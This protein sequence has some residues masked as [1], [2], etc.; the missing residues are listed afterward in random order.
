MNNSSKRI[1]IT[2]IAG[3][4]QAKKSAETL[5]FAEVG[6]MLGVSAAFISA[7]NAITPVLGGA[8]FDALGSTAPFLAGG[9]LLFLLLGVAL[10]KITP[11]PAA[12]RS[13]KTA[14]DAAD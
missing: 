8:G 9:I 14:V 12:A 5:A 4:I 7:A 6:A 13:G 1:F 2:G 11:M 3:Y 10:R